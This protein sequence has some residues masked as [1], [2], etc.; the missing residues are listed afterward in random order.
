MKCE[1]FNKDCIKYLDEY[2]GDPFDLTFL[3]PPFNQS[4]EYRSHNDKMSI[5]DYWNWMNKVIKLI[6]DNS[7]DGAAIYFMQREKNTDRKSVV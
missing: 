1:I 4:K 5:I 2:D 7:S 6:Y 3:D